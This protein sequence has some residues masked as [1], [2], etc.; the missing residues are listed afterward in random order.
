MRVLVGVVRAGRGLGQRAARATAAST[1]AA[2]RP[3]TRSRRAWRATRLILEFLM[4]AS[5][6][7]TMWMPTDRT[8]ARERVAKRSLNVG[9]AVRRGR[10]LVTSWAWPAGA[11]PRLQQ[12]RKLAQPVRAGRLFARARARSPSACSNAGSMASRSPCSSPWDFATV[13]HRATARVT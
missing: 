11:L 1:T 10:T 9:V 6:P 4:C 2:A 13:R 7:S 8:D 3:I 12:A 5:L